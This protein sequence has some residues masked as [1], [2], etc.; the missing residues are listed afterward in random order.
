MLAKAAKWRKFM[1]AINF[2][3]QKKYLQRGKDIL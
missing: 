3:S 2:F 1:H